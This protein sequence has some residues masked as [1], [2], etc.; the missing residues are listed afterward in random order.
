VSI[1]LGLDANGEKKEEEEILP[2][3]IDSIFEKKS[4]VS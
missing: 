2:I 4:S 3:C 1:C